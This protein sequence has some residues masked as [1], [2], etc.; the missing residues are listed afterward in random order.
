VGGAG[1]VSQQLQVS[2]WRLP[3]QPMLMHHAF[4]HGGVHKPVLG[5][6]C[7]CVSLPL[8]F[9][10]CTS[11]CLCLLLPSPGLL[12]STLQGHRGMVMAVRWNKK[13]DLLLSGED[14]RTRVWAWAQMN[15]TEDREHFRRAAAEQG[16]NCG[17][18]GAS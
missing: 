18:A 17:V 10:L 3:L 1:D 8:S 16:K 5:A 12:K 2:N 11:T 14:V 7:T 6:M 4:T 13:G 9:R 15:V